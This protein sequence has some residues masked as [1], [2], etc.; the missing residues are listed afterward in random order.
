MFRMVDIPEEIPGNVVH[1]LRKLFAW[2]FKTS[3]LY[4]LIRPFR[5]VI[6][7]RVMTAKTATYLKLKKQTNRIGSKKKAAACDYVF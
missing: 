2:T 4:S 1:L 3:G 7:I 6:K 5:V